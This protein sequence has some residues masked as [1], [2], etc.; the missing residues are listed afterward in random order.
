MSSSV[1]IETYYVVS[2]EDYDRYMSIKLDQTS[3][4]INVSKRIAKKLKPSLHI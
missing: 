2:K 1:A 3:K 4:I